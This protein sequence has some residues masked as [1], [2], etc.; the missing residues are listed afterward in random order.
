MA[1][2]RRKRKRTTKPAAHRAKPKSAPAAGA[3]AKDGVSA[4][5]LS[6]A[7]KAGGAQ[8]GGSPP[9]GKGP[10]AASPGDGAPR[11]PAMPP[12]QP[13]PPTPVAPSQTSTTVP[14]LPAKPPAPPS[15]TAPPAN[16]SPRPRHSQARSGA[17]RAWRG[18]KAPA[19]RPP[20]E[21]PLPAVE[22]ETAGRRARTGATVG[23]AAPG[24]VRTRPRRRLKD[25]IGP[26]RR[27][28]SAF[29]LLV[30]TVIIGVLL[31]AVLAL[32]IGAI[33]VA[34]G[35]ALNGGGSS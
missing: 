31:A 11:P 12:A 7:P 17:P 32:A 8:V 1:A 28:G 9:R 6:R 29:G 2:N 26:W 4:A 33:V 10:V 34:L 20:P 16:R 35:H 22:R 23:V 30:T 24:K 15:T 5:G 14:A 27:L 13:P 21:S 3:S 25:P 18:P 19:R